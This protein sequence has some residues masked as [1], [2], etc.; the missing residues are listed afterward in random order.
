M[1]LLSVHM[2]RIL[3]LKSWSA[4]LPCKRMLNGFPFHGERLFGD[5]LDKYIQKISR[6]KS[7]LFPVIKA[8]TR[9]SYKVPRANSSGFSDLRQFRQHQGSAAKGKQQDQGQKRKS[10]QKSANSGTKPSL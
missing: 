7:S 1:A 4:E 3:W 10:V 6:G 9:P 2:R 8:A 5:D